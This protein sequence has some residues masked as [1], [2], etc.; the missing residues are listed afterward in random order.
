M[1]PWQQSKP[2]RR[3]LTLDGGGIRGVFSLEVLARMEALLRVEYGRPDLVLADHFDLIAGTSTGAIIAAFLSWGEPVARVQAL[4]VEESARMFV[5]APFWDLRAGLF[6]STRLSAALR[7][8]FVETQAPGELT[9]RPAEL[10][11][12]RLRTLLLLV[13]RNASTGSA[14]P[15]TNNPHAKFNYPALPD[16][17]LRLPLWQIVRAS[18]AAPVYFPA[19]HVRLGPTEFSF[20]DGAI[21]A[22]NNPAAIAYLT[23]TLPSYRIGWPTGTDRLHLVSIGTGQTRTRVNEALRRWWSLLSYAAIVPAGLMDST[24]REQDL[25]CRSVGQCI[26]GA[27]IDSELGDLMGALTPPGEKRFT[28]VRYNHEFS[29]EEV[30]AAEQQYGGR[31]DLA[32]VRLIRFLQETGRRY[33]GEVRIE[34]LQ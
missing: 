24:A 15:I 19:E 26:F 27:P 4:Y 20:I 28:Y 29:R 6:E 1:K 12:E 9:A 14:W 7:E 21:T 10:G 32:N 18:T 25:F 34:H 30:L 5:R 11:T 3:I 2:R 31:F 13:M 17:N 8:F 22:Y 33:A 16:C 23:A